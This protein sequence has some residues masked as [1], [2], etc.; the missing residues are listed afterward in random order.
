MNS[1]RGI[2]SCC[3]GPQKKKII[4]DATVSVD[5]VSWLVF[6]EAYSF[7]DRADPIV[8][9]HLNL[10][11]WVTLTQGV[12]HFLYI[13]LVGITNGSSDAGETPWCLS[14][15]PNLAL[16]K[17]AWQSSIQYKGLAIQA[18]DG[19][20]EGNFWKRS[21]GLTDVDEVPWWV[22]D[23]QAEYNI[24][25]VAITN[26]GGSY[27]NLNNCNLFQLLDI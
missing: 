27:G 19:N 16:R 17:P 5:S 14:Q 7:T 25:R 12:D 23:L 2:C 18:V 10:L 9:K 6:Y 13:S 20:R 15:Y 21:C 24:M 11:S 8:P 4:M 22:V 26:R 1:F 3:K